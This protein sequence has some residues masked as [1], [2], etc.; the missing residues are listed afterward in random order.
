[1]FIQFLRIFLLFL[2]LILSYANNKQIISFLAG[3]GHQS[4]D[5]AKDK[6]AGFEKN[7]LHL[8]SVS[9]ILHKSM[10]QQTRYKFS[11]FA[12]NDKSNI[13]TSRNIGKNL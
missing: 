12:C 2:S 8:Y 10:I 6:D 5:H 7:Y 1:M 11:Y 9:N 3:D 13:N 4:D